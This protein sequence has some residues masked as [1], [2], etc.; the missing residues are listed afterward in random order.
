MKRISTF[1]LAILSLAATVAHSELCT[2]PGVAVGACISTSTCASRGGTSHKG[3]CSGG[4]DI[5]CCTGIVCDTTG[6]CMQ[7]SECS[8]TTVTGKCPGPNGYVC[9]KNLPCDSGRG[10]CMPRSKCSGTV[11]TGL[12]PGPSDYVCCSSGSTPSGGGAKIASAAESM[13]GKYPYSWGGGDNNGATKGIKQTISP[14]C[15]D[16][17]VVGFDCS[18]LSKYAVYQGTKVSLYH[19]AQTQYDNAPKRIALNNKQPGDLLFFGSSTSNIN[20]VAIYVGNNM[21]VEAPGHNS[22]CSGIKVRKV[23]VRTSNIISTVARYW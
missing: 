12:C 17:N 4:N 7:S 23:N 2:V 22:D 21:M 16:R 5:Q 14:Y 15:D 6:L 18:G 20:H 8:G 13:V 9:C 19:S 3:Y 1:L 10:T 11:K